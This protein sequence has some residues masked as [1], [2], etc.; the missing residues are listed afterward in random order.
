MKHSAVGIQKIEFCVEDRSWGNKEIYDLRGK[1][2]VGVGAELG[3]V[4]GETISVYQ[5]ISFPV[6][7][8]PDDIQQKLLSVYKDIQ[9]FVNENQDVKKRGER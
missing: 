1:V 8:L 2:Q 6:K 3:D 4:L 7:K 9:T 5:D